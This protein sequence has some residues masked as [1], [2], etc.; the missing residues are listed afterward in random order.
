MTDKLDYPAT[1]R[2]REAI[3]EVLDRVLPD[4]GALLEISAGSGQHAAFFA[5]RFP[6]LTWYP[7][8]LEAVALR[9]IDAWAAESGST[10]LQPAARLDV[11]QWPWPIDA[12]DV[13]FNAN[14][15]H[16]APWACTLGLMQGAGRLLRP[17]G[18]LIMYGPYKIDGEH[19]AP[20]NARFDASLRSRDPSWGV[21]DLGE[22]A[23]VAREHGLELEE[24][25]AMPA[26]NFTVIYRRR[27]RR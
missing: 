23:A 22:V 20:S 7:T 8:D 1:G 11:T 14:M 18:L 2:N 17:G 21:R 25:V 5:P 27:T 12:A 26:N 3:L 16:I 10:N 6:G 13:V 9:S 15:I 24:H 4:H 19:T